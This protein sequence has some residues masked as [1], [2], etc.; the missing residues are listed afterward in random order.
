MHDVNE[1]QLAEQWPPKI[2]FIEC[3][4]SES[5]QHARSPPKETR[6]FLLHS[7]PSLGLLE[8]SQEKFMAKRCNTFL[9]LQVQHTYN[10][11]S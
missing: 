8:K 6:N 1:S 3:S 9:I 11:G 10:A 2:S 5:R 7:T 4:G